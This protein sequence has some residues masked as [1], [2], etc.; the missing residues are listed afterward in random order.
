AGVTADIKTIAV[1][2]CYGIAGITALTV[3]STSA[4][5]RVEP[6]DPKILVETLGELAGDF[7]IA[8]VKIGMLASGAVA[9]ALADFLASH[10]LPNIVLDPVL[11]SS[12][13]ALL[14]DQ[15]GVKVLIE[16]LLPLVSVVTPNASEAAALTGMP[17]TGRTPN[18]TEI[19]AS[20]RKLHQM[21]AANVVITG[22]DLPEATDLL[23]FADKSTRERTF[24]EEVLKADRIVASST[25]GTGCAFATA[26]ACHLALGTDVSEAV[27]LA[28]DFVTG[29]IS[30][31]YPLG[32][33]IGPINHFYRMGER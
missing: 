7:Q 1:H 28:K 29:A 31:A 4:V 19:R 8:A 2:G 25:H 6:L 20:A 9:N 26:I 3:Q 16:R 27:K 30:H 13:G 32:R 21:G 18:G 14:L 24:K 33:G 23:S 15:D 11:V 12:S 5:R 10:K 22:G 17:T